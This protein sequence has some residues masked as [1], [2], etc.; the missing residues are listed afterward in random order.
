[1]FLLMRTTLYFKVIILLENDAALNYSLSVRTRSDD[2]LILESQGHV[3]TWK[4]NYQ[5]AI[6]NN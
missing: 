1:M 6:S 5:I 2:K 4:C 3:E